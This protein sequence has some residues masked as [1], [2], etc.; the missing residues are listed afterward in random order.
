MCNKDTNFCKWLFKNKEEIIKSSFYTSSIIKAYKTNK[1]IKEVYNFDRFKK[2]FVKENNFR[3]LKEFLKY[4]EQTKFINYLIKQNTDGYCYEDYRTACE[5]L[6][7]NMNEN[8]NRYPHDF[9]YWHDIGIDQYHT[10]KALKDKQERQELYNKFEIVANKYLGLQ[11]NLKDNFIVI[12]AKS[13]S[14]LIHEGDFLHH[15]VGRMNYD[16]KFATEESLIFFVRNKQDIETPFV[17][18]EYSLT[19]HKIL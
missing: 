7:L 4:S 19:N 17:T 10:A 12:I 14:E 3:N 9:S 5:Y 16:Q 11:R 18:L 15:C 6:G 13:P 1:P 8:K 2:S